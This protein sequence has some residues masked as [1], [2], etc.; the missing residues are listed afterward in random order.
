MYDQQITSLPPVLEIFALHG[1]TAVVTGATG[2]I[3]LEMC[4]A[5]ADAGADI[6]SI[7]IPNDP[8]GPALEEA[9]SGKQRKLRVFEGDISDTQSI[10]ATFAGMWAAGVVPDILLNCA[11]ISLRGKV[12]D[13]SD[14]AIDKVSFVFG[15][16]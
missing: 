9:I 2:G 11:G 6:V 8:Q 3:G 5:L 7:Q 12:E 1:K 15:F 4:L 16:C 13:M 14:E 10:R